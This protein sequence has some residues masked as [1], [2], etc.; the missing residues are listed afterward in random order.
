LNQLEMGEYGSTPLGKMSTGQQRRCLLARALVHQPK[1]LILDE[2]TAGLDM[3]GAASYLSAIRDL[4][5]GHH[6]I[7]VVTHHIHEIPPEVSRV[8]LLRNGTVAAD[9]DKESLLTSKVLSELYGVNLR[10]VQSS[11]FFLA[12]P[13]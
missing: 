3:T 2:P 13:E 1:T 11:G 9:G 5:A 6:N 8:V 7:V 4:A 10:V 12:H